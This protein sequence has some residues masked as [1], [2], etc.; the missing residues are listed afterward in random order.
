M[1]KRNVL[2]VLLGLAAAGLFCVGDALCQQ[3]DGGGG[4]GGGR[5]GRGGR[6]GFDPAAMRQR[7]ME[8]LKTD[9]GATDEEWKALEPKVEKVMTLSMESRMGGMFMMGRGGRGGPGGPGGP[10]GEAPA[11]APEPTTEIGKAAQ[12]LR[13]VIDN[14][15]AK[16]DEI[17]S[18]LKTYRDARAKS[19]ADLEKAQKDLKEVLTVRQEA[20]LVTRGLLE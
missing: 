13:Q 4:G 16:A 3:G 17:N 2:L 15:E 18:A 10:G 14:K 19:K 9:I 11:S 5:G 12:A 8:T 7:M 20:V 6:G 1:T